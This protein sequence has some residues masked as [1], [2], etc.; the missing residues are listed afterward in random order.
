LAA[1]FLVASLLLILQN[2]G[3]FYNPWK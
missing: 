1:L 2:Q 3:R